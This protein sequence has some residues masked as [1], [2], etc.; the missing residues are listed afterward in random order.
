MEELLAHDPGALRMLMTEDLYLLPE[1]E[2]SPAKVPA[3]PAPKAAEPKTEPEVFSYLGENNKYFLILVDDKKHQH[4]NTPDRESLLK[5]L[6]AKGLELRDVAILNV[7]R[8]PGT[9]FD[10]LKDFFVPSRIVFFGMPAQSFGLPQISSNLPEKHEGVK[11][12]T[13]F[14]FEEMQG[15]VEKKKAFWNVM[16]NF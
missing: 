8:H 15:D 7:D 16:K 11:L 13:T 1:N 6:Q 4:L 9:R 14:S 12:L 3:L 2:P 10:R 5:I